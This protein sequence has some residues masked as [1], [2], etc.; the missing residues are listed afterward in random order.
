MYLA[1]LIL[2]V[3][4]MGVKRANAQDAPEPTVTTFAPHCYTITDNQLTAYFGY[5]SN[6]VD[7]Y[8]GSGYDVTTQAGEYPDALSVTV[9]AFP[10]PDLPVITLGHYVEYQG[11]MAAFNGITDTVTISFDLST[12][13]ICGTPTVSPLPQVDSCPAYALDSSSGQSVC[14][15]SLPRVGDYQ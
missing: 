14:L 15:W 5:T 10:A 6:G 4:Y 2:L 8:F 9:E 11:A 1:L 7:R 12:L 3:V 13:P